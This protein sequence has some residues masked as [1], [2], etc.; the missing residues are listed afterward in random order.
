[1][2]HKV[3]SFHPFSTSFSSDVSRCHFSVCDSIFTRRAWQQIGRKAKKLHLPPRCFRHFSRCINQNGNEK[4]N[5]NEL[6]T[7]LAAPRRHSRRVLT[8]RRPPDDVEGLRESRRRTVLRFMEASAPCQ[9]ALPTRSTLPR[10]LV[11]THRH[12][13]LTR[14]SRE[15]CETKENGSE[16]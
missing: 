2:C 7:K 15:F 11:V 5:K 12:D 4:R 16:L 14:V 1:M 6:R 3:E 8:S 9:K 13:L 10:L